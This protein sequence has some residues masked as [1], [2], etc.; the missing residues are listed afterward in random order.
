MATFSKVYALGLAFLLTVTLSS[1]A[2]ADG[3][4]QTTPEETIVDVIMASDDFSTLAAAI[5][6]ADLV[7]ALS[8][9]GP[10]T[11]FAPT[12]DAFATLPEGTLDELLKDPARLASIL[13]FHVVPQQIISSDITSGSVGGSAV[14]TLGDSPLMFSVNGEAIMVQNATII[15]PDI[16]AANGVIHSIDTVLSPPPPPVETPTPTVE[17]A[18]PVAN[19][20]SEAPESL[21]VT[22]GNSSIVTNMLVAVVVLLALAVYQIVE[23][24][25]RQRQALSQTG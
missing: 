24:K 11:L 1:V 2:A 17:S 4:Q 3:K 14:E 5:E 8:A 7:D 23:T 18:V 9:D 20:A 12:N 15:T 22:G 6:A 19:P 10:F 16:E 13:R 25:R 21:P